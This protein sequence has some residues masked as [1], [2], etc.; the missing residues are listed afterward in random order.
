MKIIT[1]TDTLAQ[2]CAAFAQHDYVTVDTE[3]LRETTFWPILCL[4]QIAGPDDECIVDPMA[5]GIDL[6]PFFELMRDESVVKVFHAARQDVEI[7]YNLDGSIPAPLFDTQV[8][9]M[10]LG[11]GDSIAYNALVERITGDKLDKSSRFTDWSRRPLSDKQLTYALADVTHLRDVYEKLRGQLKKQGRQGWVDEEMKV[12]TNPETYDLPPEKAYTRLKARLRKPREIAVLRA[13]AQ[14]RE[15][16]AR[17]R[18]VPRG[19]VL[20]DDAVYEI[21]QQMPRSSDDLARLRAVPKGFE[22]SRNA[23]TLLAAVEDAMAIPEDELPRPPRQQRHPEGTQAAA[24]LMKVLLKVVA[25][26]HSVAAKVI[27]TADDLEKIAADDE[28]DVP[29]L[30]GWRRKMFGET[31]LELKRG[32]LAL[33]FENRK[34]ALI[35]LE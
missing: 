24:E 11:H 4:I 6:A 16:Q 21:A 15:E 34:I 23:E 8:A 26:H 25:E 20:K 19:R 10:V 2:A 29:A 1:D 28:A 3:F 22:R 9:A 7:V 17:E 30:K 27:A 14:W 32:G 5:D 12:L 33:G 35:E 31:A 13:V 18:D